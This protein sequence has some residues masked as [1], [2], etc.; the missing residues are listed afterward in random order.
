MT[1]GGNGTTAD[2]TAGQPTSTSTAS[3]T[4][5]SA[6]VGTAGPVLTSP[7][8]LGG[9]VTGWMGQEPAAIRGVTNPTLRLAAGEEYELV[10]EN[11]DG[12]EHEMKFVDGT[13]EDLA[14]SESAE[15]RGATVTMTFTAS[16]AL[17]EYYC[18][19]HPQSMRGDV[20]VVDG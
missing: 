2:P 12:L 16:P 11:L 10:W 17:T 14:E 9:D 8:R 7:I 18:E 15:D 20:V 4:G 19:Y 6:T 1:A 13:G 3:G 5:T